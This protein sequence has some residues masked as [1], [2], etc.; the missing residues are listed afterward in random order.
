MMLLVKLVEL[1]F[2]N[3]VNAANAVD[4]VDATDM[5]YDIGSAAAAADYTNAL[6]NAI[7]SVLR[8]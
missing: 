4:A 2:T 6:L 7:Y 1:I 3:T 5:F 8:S